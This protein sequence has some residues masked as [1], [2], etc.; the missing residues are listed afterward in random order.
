MIFWVPK[1]TFRVPEIF[2]C[3]P[4]DKQRP[5]FIFNVTKATILGAQNT[6]L[7][8]QNT[9]FGA[10]NTFY[11]TRFGAQN[12]VSCARKKYCLS[13]NKFSLNKCIQFFAFLHN[14][15]QFLQLQGI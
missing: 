6:F 7:G 3:G 14:S 9:F 10:Q 15:L 12:T 8:A 2:I 13:T 4:N 11:G 5:R 1:S